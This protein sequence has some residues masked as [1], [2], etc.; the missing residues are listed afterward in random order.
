MTLAPFGVV[1]PLWQ[2]SYSSSSSVCVC[3]CIP[4][5][6]FF[7]AGHFASEADCA[8][9]LVAG[10]QVECVPSFVYL[11]S[12]ITP[13]TRS[14][15]DVA[16]RIANGAKAF[17]ALLEVFRDPTLSLSTKRHLYSACVVSILLYSA[18]CWT[19]C[20]LQRRVSRVIHPVGRRLDPVENI[21][22]GHL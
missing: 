22:P 21:V 18:E 17:G 12:V 4:K 5:T 20:L 10:D 1:W 16:R 7:V 14:C 8:P 19:Q 11:G 2:P 15:H 13:D 3:A 9:I 6:K